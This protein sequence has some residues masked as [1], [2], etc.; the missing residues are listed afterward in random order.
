MKNQ[1][2]RLFRSEFEDKLK[3]PDN[4]V[5]RRCDARLKHPLLPWLVG[6]KYRDTNEKLLF[7]GKPHRG[8]AGTILPSGIVDPNKPHLKWLMDCSWAYWSY[9]K[10]AATTLFG[11]KDPWDYVCFTNIIKC[12]N[13]D[14][15]DGSNFSDKTS[16]L[17][18]KFCISDLGVIFR[19]IEVLNPKN[20]I[21]YS[22][23]MFKELLEDIPFAVA[24]KEITKK[25]HRVK[26]GNK[27][28]PWWE[29]AFETSWDNNVRILVTGHPQFMKRK[30][31][32]SL[33]TNWV[34]KACQPD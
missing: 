16:Y 21:F 27:M 26:C 30:A 14:A 1:T 33:L 5:C 3:L 31:Y 17:T 4:P 10:E 25:E 20:I 9:T 28:L 22:Y 29:R 34:R 12:T 2:L 6:S 13:T 19:E 32:I 7:V 8:N 24:V 11:K 23:S 18:A 15:E